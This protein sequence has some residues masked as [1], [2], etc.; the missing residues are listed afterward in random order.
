VE[1]IQVKQVRQ[2][3]TVPTHS[4]RYI[5]EELENQRL[6][7]ECIGEDRDGNKYYQYYSYYGLP[8]KR[9]IRFKVPGD[10]EM[11][12]L[13]YYQWLHKTVFDPPTES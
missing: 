7:R 4:F 8:T 11:R 3:R 9:E 6:N 10:W 1:S 13:V 12:D 2:L 5:G